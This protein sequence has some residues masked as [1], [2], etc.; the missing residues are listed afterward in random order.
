MNWGKGIIISFVLFAVF[1]ATLVT[2]CVRQDIPLVSKEYY[3]EEI[4]YQDQLDRL[5]NTKALTERPDISIVNN[6]IVVT[7]ARFS[8]MEHGKLK[9]FRP[10]DSSLDRQFNLDATTQSAVEI[11]VT[12]LHK[13]L[14]KARLLWEQ[15]GKEFFLEKIIV[16]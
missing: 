2:V 6:N 9:L 12:D 11:N 13:G 4:A 16:I 10:S 5:E 8:E 1:I 14:Y 3:K 15:D 7:Y